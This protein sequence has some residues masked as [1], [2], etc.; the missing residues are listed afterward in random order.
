MFFTIFLNFLLLPF[1]FSN[2]TANYYD[3]VSQPIENVYPKCFHREKIMVHKDDFKPINSYAVNPFIIPNQYRNHFKYRR[4]HDK[5]IFIILHIT[6]IDFIST[7]KLFT[8]NI[9]HGVS[10]HCV[11]A[12]PIE[13]ESDRQLLQVNICCI[14]YL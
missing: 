6:E 14:K 13:A 12:K 8:L 9:T 7:V 5:I 1:C 4:I 11:I 10:S 2:I 3:E